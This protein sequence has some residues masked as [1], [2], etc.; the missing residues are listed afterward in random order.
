MTSYY[1][2]HIEPVR[3]DIRNNLPDIEPDRYDIN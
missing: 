3:Y 2:P 1:L